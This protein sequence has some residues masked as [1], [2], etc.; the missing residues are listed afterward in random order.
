MT[1]AF[2]ARWAASFAASRDHPW[3][4]WTACL[5]QIGRLVA[6]SGPAPALLD[7]ACGNLRFLDFLQDRFP[8]TPWTCFGVDAEAG[9]A[10]AGRQIQTLDIMEALFADDLSTRLRNPVVDLG[11]CFGFLHHVPLQE[12]RRGL[13]KALVDQTRPQGLVILTAWQFARD[14]AARRKAEAAT[15]RARRSQ[16]PIS[17]DEGDYLLGWQGDEATPRYCHSF[18][19]TEIDDL[20]AAVDGRAR[21]IGRFRAD[22]RTGQMNTYLILQKEGA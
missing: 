4:G 20:V 21:L 5:P 15:R 2:Y 22:G 10:P 6:Q 14:E 16:A 17:L 19:E 9:M 18:S 3:P 7:L 1:R 8:A 13:V 12:A 11:V